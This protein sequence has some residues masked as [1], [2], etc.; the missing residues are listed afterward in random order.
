MDRDLPETPA[1]VLG[2]SGGSGTRVAGQL[3]RAAGGY[4]GGARNEAGDSLALVAAIEALAARGA[5]LLEGGRPEEAD[6]ALWHAA[7]TEHLA[8]HAGEPFWGWKNPRS[9]FLLPFSVALVPGLRFIHMVRDGRDMALSG[10]RR[11]YE[12]H[13]PEGPGTP[14][15][16]A[17][18]WAE[19]NLRV[20]R[21]A[22]AV[23][24]DRY[25]ILRFEDLCRDP[26]GCMARLGRQFGLR[27]EPAGTGIEVRPPD[28]VGRHRALPAADRAAVEA[29]A[30]P[31]ME[32][33]GY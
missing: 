29:A 6:L 5:R 8:L 9:M 23:L 14:A 31:A 25:A 33:F 2:A 20:K 26:E 24:G 16:R 19:S 12:R 21:H 30:A 22:E 3:L 17:R 27:L 1:L 10:N 7:L 4:L 15:D 32:A 18:F 11:Q 28:G 13:V